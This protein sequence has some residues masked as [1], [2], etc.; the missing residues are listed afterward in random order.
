MGI[1]GVRSGG[2]V[3]CLRVRGERLGGRVTLPLLKEISSGRVSVRG[4]PSSHNSPTDHNHEPQSI[5]GA[6][7]LDGRN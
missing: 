1:G 3:V 7:T 2:G 5:R 4:P 6:A